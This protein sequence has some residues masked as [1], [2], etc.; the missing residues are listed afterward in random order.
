MLHLNKIIKNKRI[1]TFLLDVILT[2]G[3]IGFLI[4]L[5]TKTEQQVKLAM[6]LAAPLY[7]IQEKLTQ[8]NLGLVNTVDLDSLN[9]LIQ[10]SLFLNHILLPVVIIISFL[11]IQFNNFSVEI[12]L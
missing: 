3:I 8:D 2:T 11:I 10:K 1:Q 7:D 6:G 4:Y 9:A 5:R 12:E